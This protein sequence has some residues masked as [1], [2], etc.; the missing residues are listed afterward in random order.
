MKN[1]PPCILYVMTENN[2]VFTIV[3]KYS[4]EYLL[5][6]RTFNAVSMILYI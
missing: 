5:I 4:P 1:D 2:P 3:S 6:R